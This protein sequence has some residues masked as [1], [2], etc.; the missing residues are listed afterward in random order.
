MAKESR[1]RQKMTPAEKPVSR[2]A[3]ATAAPAKVKHGLAAPPKQPADV[4]DQFRA[5]MKLS[6]DVPAPKVFAEALARLGQLHAMK[7]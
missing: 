3:A 1:N 4:V 2:P 7:K 6:P 5:V